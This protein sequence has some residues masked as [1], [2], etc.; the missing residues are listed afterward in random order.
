M[1]LQ[2]KRIIKTKPN[3]RIRPTSQPVPDLEGEGYGGPFPR[4]PG[5]LGTPQRQKLRGD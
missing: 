4:E 2:I 1:H 5:H 3:T